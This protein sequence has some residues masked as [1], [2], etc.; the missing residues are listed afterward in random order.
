MTHKVHVHLDPE[1]NQYEANLEQVAR[2]TLSIAQA[3]SGEV[4]I[5]LVDEQRIQDLN[6]KFLK[7]DVPTDVIS[8]QGESLDPDTG[9][10]YLGDV[11]IALPIAETQAASADHSVEAELSLLAIHGVLHL[12]GYD[13]TTDDEKA[14]M[15][16][17]QSTIV[18]Q[19]ELRINEPT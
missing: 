15:W 16:Q 8:F 11:I 10:T 6:R 13:H 4:S 1:H 9:L 19:I 18:G 7:R 14:R 12:L 3:P 2:K 17:L 5:V